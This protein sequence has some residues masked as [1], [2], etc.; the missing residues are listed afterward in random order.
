MC[1]IIKPPS[2]G[3]KNILK[4]FVFIEICPVNI[5]KMIAQ[6]IEYIDVRERMSHLHRLYIIYL[7]DKKLSYVDFHNSR[8][9]R[10]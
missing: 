5:D 4:S 8:W 3:L 9:R 1:V 10:N 2:N 7:G 6:H